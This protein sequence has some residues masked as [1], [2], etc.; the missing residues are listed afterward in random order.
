M[1]DTKTREL[2]IYDDIG[3][4]WSG[5]VGTQTI[6]KGL[7]QLGSGPVTVRVN[8]YGG[9]VDEGLAM[10]E[11]LARH[12][13]EVSVSVDSIAASAASLFP[14]AFPSTAAKHARIMIHNPW[15][16]VMGGA[17]E[18]RKTADILDTYRDSVATVYAQGMTVDHQEILDLMEAE[19]WYSAEQA[20]EVGLVDMVT[21]ADEPIA[22]KSCQPGR[23]KNAP[24]DLIDTTSPPP[25]PKADPLRVAAKLR[26]MKLAAELRRRKQK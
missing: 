16:M 26:A 21:V 23:F 3:P 12:D 10:L 20:M 11:V 6:L 22:A 8:S 24:A 19:T 13:G 5:L 14:V 17:V 15:G 9:A 2:F 1:I 18:M 4:D 25:A 7:A